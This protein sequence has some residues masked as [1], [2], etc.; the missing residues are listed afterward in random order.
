MNLHMK[1]IYKSNYSIV[2][3]TRLIN[4]KIK[5]KGR[6]SRMLDI[7]NEPNGKI[8]FIVNYHKYSVQRSILLLGE[9]GRIR[10]PRLLHQVFFVIKLIYFLFLYIFTLIICRFNLAT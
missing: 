6:L 10:P 4:N 5:I 9:P 2:L 7:Q 3:H 8:V 1:N